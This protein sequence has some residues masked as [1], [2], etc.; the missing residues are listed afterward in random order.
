MSWWDNA[1]EEQRLTQIKAGLELGMTQG[2]IA[3]NLKV[4]RITVNRLSVKHKLDFDEV[5]RREAVRKFNESYPDEA[6]IID[7]SGKIDNTSLPFSFDIF[8]NY[9]TKWQ[10]NYLDNPEG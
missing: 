1:T 3:K 10:L 8:S 7:Q 5:S 6:R 2:Q 4:H 9:D